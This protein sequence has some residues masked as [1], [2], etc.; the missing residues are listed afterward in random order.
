MSVATVHI[1]R[2][3]GP[4]CE[5]KWVTYELPFEE[6]MTV[7]GVFD[8]IYE[9]LDTSLAH[10][11]SCRNGRCVG[12]LVQVN[13]KPVLACETIASDGMRAGPL[14]NYELIRDLVIDF[15]KPIK[16]AT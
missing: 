13:G 11:Q 14:E 15:N 6:R 1:K 8:Y 10:Y 3:D 7:L 5:A 16:K 9:N 12:C 4:G 2:C